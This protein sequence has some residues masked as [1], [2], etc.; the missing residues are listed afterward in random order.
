MT[1]SRIFVYGTLQDEQLVE[2]LTGRRF[3]SRP[4]VLQGYYRMFDPAIGYPVV[5]PRAGAAVDGRILD[6]VG[7]VALAALDTYEGHEYRRSIV[8][9]RTV[10][11]TT[12]EAYI[13][14]PVPVGTPASGLPES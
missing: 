7:A 6:D 13:Y 8:N 9:V 11:G 4:A 1:V 12:V 10:D 2:R 5:R 3:P 14:L